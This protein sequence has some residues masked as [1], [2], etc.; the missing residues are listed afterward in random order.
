[1]NWWRPFE[2]CVENLEEARTR[3]PEYVES[4][5]ASTKSR[6][7]KLHKDC[8]AADE[9]VRAAGGR[10]VKPVHQHYSDDK[11]HENCVACNAPGWSFV[12]MTAKHE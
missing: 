1:V 8:R 5:L 7:C 4:R 12:V 11:T 6:T 3:E 9:A 2:Q 10:E